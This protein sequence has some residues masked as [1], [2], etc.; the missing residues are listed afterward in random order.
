MCAR[1][2]Y[3]P[4]TSVFTLKAPHMAPLPGVPGCSLH[5]ESRALSMRIHTAR[6]TWARNAK[7]EGQNWLEASEQSW[8]VPHPPRPPK[9]SSRPPAGLS[10]VLCG[11]RNFPLC[12]P[13]SC[14]AVR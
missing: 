2:T 1:G 13:K 10:I 4:V 6:L 3:T 8:L 14:I 9:L 7:A 5:A 11:Q 12:L